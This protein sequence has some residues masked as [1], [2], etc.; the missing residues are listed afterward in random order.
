MPAPR[1][2]PGGTRGTVYRAIGRL[3]L[4]DA[5]FLLQKERYNGAIYLAGYAIECHLKFAVCDRKD[6]T[7]LPSKME[8]HD[9][10]TLA[11]GA[12]LVSEINGQR[13]VR[14]LYFALAERWG[15]SLRYS[16]KKYSAREA[17]LLY[18]EMEELYRFLADLVP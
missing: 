10:D 17:E 15:P 14:A 7:Y 8:V 13:E 11:A 6:L 3:R 4:E 9:W 2:S 18:N 1:R 5:A 12:G 16:S